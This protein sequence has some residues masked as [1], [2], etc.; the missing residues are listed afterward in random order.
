MSK[1]DSVASEV[2]SLPSNSSG[3]KQINYDVNV[4]D[5]ESLRPDTDSLENNVFEKEANLDRGLKQR[6]IQM[7]SLVGVFGTGL[8]LSSGKTLYLTGNVGMFLSYLFIGILVGL[9]Q[10]AM[11]ELS[12]LMPV[13]G[14]YIRH[15]DHFVDGAYSFALG[16]IGVYQHILPSE[17]SASALV[18]GYWSDLNP[19]VWITVFMVIIIGCNSWKIRFYGEIE[20]FFGCLKVLL[21]T[22]LII[23]CIVMDLGG[24]AGVDR[25]GFRYWK[26]TPFKEYYTDGSLGEF[27]AWWKAAGSVVYA[28][29]GVNAISFY[30]GE[31]Q[32]PR[33]SIYTAGK[34]IFFRVFVLYLLTVFGLTLILSADNP[35]I[36][37]TT[38][39][40]TGSPFVI[41]IKDAGI[42]GLPSV[43]NAVVLTSAFSAANMGLVQ[44]SRNLFALASKGQAPRFFLKTNRFGLPY[45]GVLVSA[46]F[47]PLAYMSAS[48]SA[49]TVFG[50]FQNLT[51]ANL[52]VVWIAIDINHIGLQKALKAQG[53]TRDDLPYK[54][55]FADYAAYISL[56]FFILLL[57]TGGYANFLD[58]NF[59]ISSFFSSYFVIPLFIVLFFFWKIVKKTHHK[60]SEDVD[61]ETLFKDVEAN[62]ET[63]PPPNR[64]WRII[65]YLWE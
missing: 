30:A 62:P 34:R 56:F 12:C 5:V 60:K 33:F 63:I 8:F 37:D 54:M 29:G 65:K 41:A 45:W 26:D 17:I 16:W 61:L 3:S 9:N 43:I 64:G 42:Q 48:S 51:S 25:I 28:F 7:L 15:G 27:L 52:L 53:Y 24:V 57:L 23:L 1:N 11:I 59:D 47:M 20:F 4:V 22:G 49:S 31:T 10:L 35:Q 58:D 40:S 19:A 6:H 55:P 13:T 2:A 44:T 38:G 18:M 32:R 50:W 21:I 39:D 14:S 36:A 46:A